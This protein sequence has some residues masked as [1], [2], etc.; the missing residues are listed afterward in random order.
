M[1]DYEIIILLKDFSWKNIN[2]PY[3]SVLMFSFQ[4]EYTRVIMLSNFNSQLYNPQ[5]RPQKI[6]ELG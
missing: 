2:L 3:I 4:F 5:N 1:T 6:V